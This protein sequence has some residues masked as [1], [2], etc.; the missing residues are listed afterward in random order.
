MIRSKILAFSS[1]VKCALY[2]NSA[3]ID[4]G[5]D[6]RHGEWLYLLS[7][8]DIYIKGRYVLVLSFSLSFVLD[9]NHDV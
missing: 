8:R 4:F 7:G 3:F 1:H 5:V 9:S 6:G 2:G